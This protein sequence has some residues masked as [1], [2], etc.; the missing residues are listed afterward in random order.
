MTKPIHED[1]R[2][3]LDPQLTPLE[4]GTGQL[5]PVKGEGLRLVTDPCNARQYSDAQIYD[6]AHM[7]RR[8]YPSR[9]PLRMVVRAWASGDELTGTAGF[10]FWNQPAMPGQLDV[11][12]PRAVW[13][14]YGSRHSNMAFVQ[15]VPGHGWKAATLDAS[16]L[17]FLLLAPTAPLGFLLMR[18]QALYRKLW[19]IGQW[20]IGAA[21]TL[22]DARLIEPHT[23]RLDW[24]P[25][26]AKFF[27]DDRL[28]LDTP[29]S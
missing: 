11:R 10:G 25:D 4:I 9:P 5:E 24:L 18:S 13:F 27:V 20:A 26:S 17:P 23:Y 16:R 2:N 28:I 1:F 3:G 21:E 29:F 8:D 7:K 15:G 12:L 6:Y 19:P 14:F 22:I